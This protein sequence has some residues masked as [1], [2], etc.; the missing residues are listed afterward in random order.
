MYYS[1]M[2]LDGWEAFKCTVITVTEHS[3]NHKQTH[4]TQKANALSLQKKVDTKWTPTMIQS[5]APLLSWTMTGK[6]EMA[7]PG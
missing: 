1:K 7:V 2:A 4:T 3:I 5:S 6:G